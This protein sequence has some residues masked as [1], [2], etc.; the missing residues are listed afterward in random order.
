MKRKI[1]CTALCVGHSVSGNHRPHAENKRCHLAIPYRWKNLCNKGTFPWYYHFRVCNFDVLK[2]ENRRNCFKVVLHWST[3]NANLQRRFAT[4]VS[5]TNFSKTCNTLQ[6]CKYREKSFA[7]GRYTKMIFRATS[8]HCKLGLQVDQCNTTFSV[9][10]SQ[11]RTIQDISFPVFRIMNPFFHSYFINHQTH[12]TTW[13][14]PRFGAPEQIQMQNIR[15]AA[16]SFCK[17]NDLHTL[18]FNDLYD[19]IQNYIHVIIF[20]LRPAVALTQTS[21]YITHKNLA[22]RKI[23]EAMRT[24]YA[25]NRTWFPHV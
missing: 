25:Q 22:V 12:T 5:R 3:C 18:C 21:A 15:P 2:M 11:S 6:H 1:L 13:K 24:A 20:Y 10:S 16:V 7:T 14:D 8:Y 23:M 9:K 17:E 19:W 4:H